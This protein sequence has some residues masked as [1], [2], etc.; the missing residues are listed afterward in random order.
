MDAISTPNWDPLPYPIAPSRHLE[1]RLSLFPVPWFWV[2]HSLFLGSGLTILCS[3]THPMV[4]PGCHSLA[5]FL[6]RASVEGPLAVAA[7]VGS[8]QV[9]AAQVS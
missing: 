5:H 7:Q 3:T 4:N 2:D 6:L 9:S 1:P 8:A